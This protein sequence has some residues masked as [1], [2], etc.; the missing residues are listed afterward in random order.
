MNAHLAEVGLS[1]RTMLKLA[2]VGAVTTLLPAC[3][4]GDAGGVSWQAIPPYSL[5]GTDPKRVS[6]L[7]AQLEGFTAEGG[8][9]I[10]PEVSS[11]DTAAAMSKLLLQASQGR[12]PDVAQ[13]D[14][15]I[16]GRLARYAQPLNDQLTRHGLHLD[17]WFPSLQKVM[18][19]GGQTVR[20]LQFTSD[21][22]V[23]YYRKD[24]VPRPPATW[25]ELISMAKP[26]RES[27]LQVLFPAGRSEGAVTTTV[28]PQVWAQGA[29]LINADGEPAFES[30]KGYDAMREALAVVERCVKA[31]I[32]PHRVATFGKEDDQASDV[33]A[34]RVAMFLGGNWQAAAINNVLPDKD[35]FEKW[36]VAP[37]PSIS[38]ERHVT[39]AGGWVWAGFTDDQ[40]K[41]DTGVDWV[42][43]TFVSD[44]GMAAWCSAGGYLPPRQS[45]Y[46][47]P[48]YTQNRFTPVFRQH[49]AEYSRTRPGARKYLA[50]SN[51]I[52]I[53]LSSVA[54]GDSSADRALDQALNRIA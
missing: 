3:S 38:G 34:G 47:R 31:G 42:M 28:W 15:Y 24:V 32:T 44:E 48:D 18:T 22:R 8:R 19:G 36:G 46:D 23:L 40:Q 12:A 45:V 14:G 17:D 29:E 49:L 6:Y 7:R 9:R 43:R 52:Q 33:V 51:T 25:D 21:V 10:I 5:Q 41:I 35:F 13:V 4:V 16:F 30:G 27:G 26:L 39:S 50:V 20:G 11:A 53:A 2:G 54:S 1:R 37:I